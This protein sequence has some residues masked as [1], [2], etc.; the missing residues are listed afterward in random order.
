MERGIGADCALVTCMIQLA[1]IIV[2]LGIGALVT[3][4]NTVT[5]TVAAAS[6]TS[7]LGSVYVL[8]FVKYS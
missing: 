6:V 3:L 5:V 4:L 7:F 8:I 2:G 1:Q